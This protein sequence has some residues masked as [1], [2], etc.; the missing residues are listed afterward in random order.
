MD[1]QTLD[2]IAGLENLKIYVHKTATDNYFPIHGKQ[3][4]WNMVMSHEEV[5]QWMI[6]SLPVKTF[7]K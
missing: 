2:T 1:R 7:E 5:L 3:A 4:Y 6:R